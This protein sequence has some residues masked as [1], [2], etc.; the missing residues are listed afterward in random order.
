VNGGSVPDIPTEDSPISDSLAPPSDINSLV[1]GGG[2][3][4]GFPDLPENSISLNNQASA[5]PDVIGDVAQMPFASNSF[6]DVKYE[7]LPYSS[8]T[9]ENIGAIAQTA[10]VLAPGGELTI[11]TGRAAPLSEIL[12]TLGEVGFSSIAIESTDPL[13]ISALWGLVVIP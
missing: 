11:V 2:N 13:I 7:S 8:F 1:V 4:P 3:A 12:A 10:D 5:Q 6:N 9:G